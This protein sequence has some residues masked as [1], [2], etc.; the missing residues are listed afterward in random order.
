MMKSQLK[1][2]KHIWVLNFL[3]RTFNATRYY[4]KKY[5]EIIKWGIASNE[6]TNYTY[7]L[8]EGNML[9]L[10]HIISFVVQKDNKTILAFINEAQNDTFLKDHIIRE[11]Q[12]SD[13]K[14]FADQQIRFGRRMGWYAMIRALKPRTVVETGVDKGLGSVIICAA[15]LKNKEEG[16]EGRYYGTDINPKAGYLLTGKY[17]QVGE[18]LYGDSIASLSTFKDTIDIFINDSD[19]SA[20]Y[21]YR[22]YLT[23][24]HLLTDD[25]I[26]LGDNSHST[27]KLAIFSTEE[28]RNFL[29]FQ[30]SPLNHWYPGGGIGISFKTPKTSRQ[31]Q[32]KI[33][34]ESNT[35]NTVSMQ[36]ASN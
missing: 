14:K 1:K 3:R 12:Q 16:F 33:T 17:R 4:N 21:E 29:F 18:I 35:D 10:A 25:S 20:D 19:H 13:L 26:I 5:M 24:K 30:E 7:D 22:E 11:I 9:Y 34:P 32:N 15:L 28:E 8:T 31:A 23:I 6:D 36:A 27:D 2:L